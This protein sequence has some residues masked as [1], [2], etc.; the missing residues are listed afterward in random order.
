[1]E[2]TYFGHSSFLIK[3]RDCRIVTDPFDPKTAGIPMPKVQADIVTISHGNGHDSTVSAASVEGSPMVFDWPGEFEKNG[4]RIFGI[5]SRGDKNQGEARVE[6][7]IF[8]FDIE[9]IQTVHCGELGSIADTRLL[10]EIG[11]VDILMIPVGGYGTIDVKEAAAMAKKLDPSII[12][13]MRYAHD[14]LP[15]SLAGKLA[16]LDQ[17]MSAMGAEAVEPVGK[18]S[19]KKEDLAELELKIVPM[20]F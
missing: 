5:Q 16:P 17:F 14:K 20:S 15:P 8:K 13:P 11:E 12:I 3:T 18:L 19:L 2:I 6:N 10:E 9:G 1:M 7:V 4:V